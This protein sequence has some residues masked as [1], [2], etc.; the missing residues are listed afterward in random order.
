[1]NRRSF[2]AAAASTVLLLSGC[3]GQSGPA[4]IATIS[5]QTDA[6]LPVSA[7]KPATQGKPIFIEFYS[8]T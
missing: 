5:V 2:A 3:G 4:P 8:V 7:A 1:M 6:S